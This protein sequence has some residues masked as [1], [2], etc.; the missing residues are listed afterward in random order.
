MNARAVAQHALIDAQTAA[1][2]GE[3][4]LASTMIL[5]SALNFIAS[6]G[7]MYAETWKSCRRVLEDRR[8]KGDGG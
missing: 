8:Y 5:L 3:G 2:M 6:N 1:L 4:D 7:E